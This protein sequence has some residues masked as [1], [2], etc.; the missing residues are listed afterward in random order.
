MNRILVVGA[1]AVAA[2]ALNRAAQAERERR[3]AEARAQ[4]IQK[5]RNEEK[6]E[7][8]EFRYWKAIE[9]EDA[10]QYLAEREIWWNMYATDED[11]ARRMETR[12]RIQQEMWELDAIESG[13]D[14]DE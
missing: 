2:W 11:R 4:L 8:D 10:E 6:A 7:L 9:D 1:I 12:R 3:R 13:G 14:D 5:K